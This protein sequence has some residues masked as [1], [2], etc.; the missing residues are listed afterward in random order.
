MPATLQR[1]A[2]PTFAEAASGNAAWM[3]DL[4]G[5]K[6]NIRGHYCAWP[7]TEPSARKTLPY[8][9]AMTTQLPS[10]KGRV[11]DHW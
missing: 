7:W 6:L 10:S 4:M 9:A 8:L 5:Q 2:H 11:T 1:G 3:F